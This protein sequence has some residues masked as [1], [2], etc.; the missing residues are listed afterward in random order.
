MPLTP[1]ANCLHNAATM[2][3]SAIADRLTCFSVAWQSRRALSHEVELRVDAVEDALVALQDEARRAQRSA[4]AQAE[5]T[6]TLQSEVASLGGAAAQQAAT[7]EAKL[8]AMQRDA[9]ASKQAQEKQAAELAALRAELVA[10][11]KDAAGARAD[12]A[13]LAKRL[14]AAT[15]A[16][17]GTQAKVE[18][19]QRAAE[20]SQVRFADLLGRC[21][22]ARCLMCVQPSGCSP[23]L[24]LIC[25]PHVLPMAQPPLEHCLA[26]VNAKTCPDGNTPIAV[27]VL[28]EAHEGLAATA[29]SHDDLAAVHSQVAALAATLRKAMGDGPETFHEMRVRHPSCGL[30]R[31]SQMSSQFS[32]RCS[33]RLSAVGSWCT[34]GI[35]ATKP[36]AEWCFITHPV[37]SH[38]PS[39]RPPASQETVAQ[40]KQQ[41]IEMNDMMRRFEQMIADSD[42]AAHIASLEEAM[43]RVVGELHVLHYATDQ[44]IKPHPAGE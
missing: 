17:K 9:A 5:T 27:S 22:V 37:L 8:A 14:D 41:V 25:S 13:A 10:A 43:G 38:N 29:A 20:A 1:L 24:K 2:Q 23:A 42:H 36:R 6:A 32:W 30:I 18:R 7:W 39:R 34:A 44:L 26:H 11:R 16:Q 21:H 19:L 31:H 35:K 40:R 28:Q 15:A 33:P 4:A 3:P 12:A